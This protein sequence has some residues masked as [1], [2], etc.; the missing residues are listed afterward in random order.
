MMQMSHQPEAQDVCDEIDNDCDG[1]IDNNT[2]VN[3]PTWYMDADGDERGR[4]QMLTE[5]ER[6]TMPMGM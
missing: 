5:M 3:T 1:N 6:L 4:P 2:D